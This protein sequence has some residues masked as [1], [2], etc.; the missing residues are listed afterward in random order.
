MRHVDPANGPVAGQHNF[1]RGGAL[2]VYDAQARQ[3]L[4]ALSG[5]I[6]KRAASEVWER[7]LTTSWTKPPVWVHGDVSVGNL[8]VRNGRLCA[9]IDFGNSGIG[10]PACDLA[11]A[12]T[13]FEGQS[14]DAFQKSLSLDDATWERGRGW[15]L[16]KAMI[17]AAGISTSNAFEAQ[18]PLRIIDEVIAD[19]LSSNAP[20]ARAEE[21]SN[22]RS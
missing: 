6:N 21:R 2:R 10:D 14:R 3:A 13:L 19:H 12:W 16:W 4:D 20:S 9:V 5:K 11:I 15:V 18:H 22:G 7:A 17:I 1:Y 8:L